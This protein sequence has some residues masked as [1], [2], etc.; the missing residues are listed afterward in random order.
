M[1]EKVKHRPIWRPFAPLIL[2]ED[3][4]DWFVKPIESPYMSHRCQFKESM[5]DKVSSVVHNDG[6]G[7]LQ[8]VNSKQNPWLHGFLNGWK[9][10]S[11]VPILINTS[12]N[13]KEPIVET[14]YH[15]VACFQRTNIDILYFPEYKLIA[16]KDKDTEKRE[17]GKI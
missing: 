14:P 6:T 17:E 5:K 13:D 2:E 3:I 11:G 12:F 1:N 15:A 4:S 9:E 10:Y 7:R 16:Y 8:T